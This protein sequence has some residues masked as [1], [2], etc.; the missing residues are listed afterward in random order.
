MPIPP[1]SR[2]TAQ[3]HR[4]PSQGC[5][6]WI[7]GTLVALLGVGSASAHA[8]LAEPADPYSPRIEVESLPHAMRARSVVSTTRVLFDTPADGL[9]TRMWW[10]KGALEVGAGA[11]VS[12]SNKAQGLAT[13]PRVG[14]AVVGL[15]AQL[16]RGTH[17]AIERDT[18]STNVN[19]GAAAPG[20]ISRV[21]LEFKAVG[22]SKSVQPL[23]SGS[24]R[25]QMSG[26]SSL[27]FRPRSG[28]MAVTYRAKF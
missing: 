3:A 21:A 17:L 20:E 10:G 19:S 18:L 1:P 7:C 23:S 9:R 26:T 28:G 8:A 27:Q 4:L 13:S 6:G 22:N 5:S 14:T 24:L 11:N 2:A 12:P 15:R 16:G 25:V